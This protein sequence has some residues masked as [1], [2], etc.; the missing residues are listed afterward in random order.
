[1]HIRTRTLL[2]AVAL[3]IA[4]TPA[5]ADGICGVKGDTAPVIVAALRAQ[6]LTTQ[7]APSQYEAFADNDRRILWALT[8][9]GHPAHPSVVCR[10]VVQTGPEMKVEMQAQC[11]GPQAACDALVREFQ[12]LTDMMRRTVQPRQ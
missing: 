6:K 2:T 4:S 12:S 1:M 9:E 10:Q 8:K 5:A 11:D 3:V 7:P